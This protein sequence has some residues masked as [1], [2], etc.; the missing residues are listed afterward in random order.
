VGTVAESSVN[1]DGLRR[2]AFARF[3]KA[4]WRAADEVAGRGGAFTG[5]LVTGHNILR[6]VLIRGDTYVTI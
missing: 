5:F 1:S 2:A 3:S 6:T 4:L